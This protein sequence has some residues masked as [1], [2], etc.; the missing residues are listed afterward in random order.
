MEI[1]KQIKFEMWIYIL[2][3]SSRRVFFGK[4]KQ[5]DMI[6]SEH[7]ESEQK[8]SFTHRIYRQKR[9]N[10]KYLKEKNATKLNQHESGRI[11][12]KIQLRRWNVIFN[13]EFSHRNKQNDVNIRLCAAFLASCKVPMAT[14]IFLSISFSFKPLEFYF[15]VSLSISLSLFR[16]I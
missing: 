3:P 15:S 11:K 12:D 7:S 14:V 6:M 16:I 5:I 4:H 8:K 9:K 1:A 2:Y 10:M 13:G